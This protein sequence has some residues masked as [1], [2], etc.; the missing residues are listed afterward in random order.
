MF[1]H[2][3]HD[4]AARLLHVGADIGQ[5]VLTISPVCFRQ[6]ITHALLLHFILHIMCCIIVTWWCGPGGIEA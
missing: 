6:F 3:Q 2:S 4:A 5:T 1:A